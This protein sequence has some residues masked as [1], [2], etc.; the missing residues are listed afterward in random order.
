MIVSTFCSFI[1]SLFAAF[2]YGTP[3]SSALN[4]HTPHPFFIAVTEINHNAQDKTLEI[5]CKMFADDL[6]QILEKDY[7]KQLDI[8]AVKDKALCDKLIADYVRHHLG[9]TVDGR[10]VQESYVGFEKDKESAY[11]YF[12]VNDVA[13]FHKLNIY[14]SILHDFNNTQINIIHVMEGGKRQ[15]TK[16]DYPNTQASF[17]F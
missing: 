16:L 2:A 13:S 12:Q 17:A 14:N 11:C 7:K 6:E 8:A 1:L 5:S 9:L 10:A 15:S 4:A 3:A